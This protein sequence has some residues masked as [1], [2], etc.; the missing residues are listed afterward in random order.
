M[1]DIK[2]GPAGSE[3]ILPKGVEVEVLVTPSKK[4]SKVEM[5]DGS[6][7]YGFKKIQGK[8]KL[9]WRPR[10]LSDIETLRNLNNLN[11]VLHYQNTHESATWYY[12]IIDDFFYK[13]VMSGS[14]VK[15]TAEMK[16]EEAV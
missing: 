11:E 14:T 1:P 12:V 6:Y 3:T 8:W 9:K 4:I 10:P 16:L 7:R 2:L 5:S 13:S 15:Y